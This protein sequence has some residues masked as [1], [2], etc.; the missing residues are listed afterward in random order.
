[1]FPRVLRREHKSSEDLTT[2]VIAKRQR[3]IDIEEGRINP[4]APTTKADD[5]GRVISGKVISFAITTM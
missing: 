2:L 1:M 3:E 4:Y 5:E